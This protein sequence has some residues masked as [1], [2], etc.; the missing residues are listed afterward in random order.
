MAADSAPSQSGHVWRFFRAGGINQVDLRSGADL[1]ALD[2]LDPK[3]WVTL[4]CPTKGLEFD[5]YTLR[6]ID[7]DGDGRVRLPEILAALR[8]ALQRVKNP[9]DLL[10]GEQS[11][12]L[13]AVNAAD[14]DGSRIAA[15]ARRILA[16]AGKGGE[17]AIGPAETEKAALS[18][19]QTKLNGDGIVPPD[20]AEAPETRRVLEEII[21]T[22]GAE[23][24][25]SGKPGVSQAKA[26]SFFSECRA[27][28]DWWKQAEQAPEVLP[29]GKDT[30]AAYAALQSVRPKVDDYFVRCRLAAYDARAAAPLNRTD[31]AFAAMAGKD[32]T[33]DA[34]DIR[35][36]PLARVEAGR[37]LPLRDGVNPAWRPALSEL[38]RLVVEPL[39]K[40]DGPALAEEDWERLK[41]SFAPHE[42][43]LASKK[44][45]AVEGLGIDRVRSLASGKSRTD[46]DKIIAEDLALKAEFEAVEAVDR[47]THYYRDLYRLLLNFV[48]FAEFYG[49]RRP[50]VFQAGRLFMDGRSCDLCIRVA[51]PG[52]HAAMASASRMFLLYCDCFRKDSEERLC[53]AAALTAGNSDHI[54]VGRNGVF[55]DRQGRDWD[56]TV[57]KVV[58]H[59]ISIR[60]AVWSPYVRLARFIGEQI[61]KLASARDKAV[62]E[63]MGSEIETR[64]KAADEGR[65]V[66]KAP[67]FDVAKFA[68]IF[69]AIG[70][71]IGGIAAGVGKLVE[72]FAGL[73]WWQK[74][75]AVVGIFAAVSGPS[76]FIAWLKLRQRNLG[77]LLDANGW[78][79]NSLVKINIPF[80]AA[81]TSVAKLPAGAEQSLVDP[82][83]P[84]RG[85]AAAYGWAVL[86]A[87]ALLGLALWAAGGPTG[88]LRLLGAAR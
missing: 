31:E 70:L 78:G 14:Q 68:G 41:R 19:S 88:L 59:P 72:A 74:P 75:L 7:S 63:K 51:D 10:K 76:V 60:Q 54:F 27:Y 28:C 65:P 42:A 64:V 47:L 38:R 30:A 1:A 18:F 25:R 80:G 71:A 87:G 61:E 20:S 44:G 84:E 69:A 62:T 36:L 56:A 35:R 40:A 13:D 4:S 34:D 66:E 46:V 17:K 37:G 26:D 79:I 82:Y 49:R 45:A 9:D 22:L 2:S 83:A 3:L 23:A 15:S 5:A 53:V 8:W 6:L 86:I 11:M 39:L 48:S 57:V 81:L 67:P 33:A 55:Y 16:N 12:P 21:Q 29:R 77:P 85:R 50:A 58:E 32:L 24:D 52:K 73:L 43:W